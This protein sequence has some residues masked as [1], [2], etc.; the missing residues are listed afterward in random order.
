[1]V[2]NEENERDDEENGD[3]RPEADEDEDDDATP[4]EFIDRPENLPGDQ[5]E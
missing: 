1:M 5:P 2:M 3:A 4:A